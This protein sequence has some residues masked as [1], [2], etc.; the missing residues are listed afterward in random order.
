MFIIVS[1]TS[2]QMVK[3]H[4]ISYTV[5]YYEKS[6]QLFK[7]KKKSICVEIFLYKA[8]CS[9]T[10]SAALKPSQWPRLIDPSFKTVERGIE[11]ASG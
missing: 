11:P 5:Y 3:C 4:H 6:K 10:V 9:V 8:E 7:K 2:G 1:L